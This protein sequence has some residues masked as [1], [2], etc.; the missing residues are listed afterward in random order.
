MLYWPRQGVPPL[1]P[2]P[3]SLSLWSLS[4]PPPSIRPHSPLPPSLPPLR[5]FL[6]QATRELLLEAFPAA[7]EGDLTALEA[8]LCSGA[9]AY[10]HGL[11]FGLPRL[12]ALDAHSLRGWGSYRPRVVGDAFEAVLGAAL[13]ALGWEAARGAVRGAVAGA[14]ERGGTVAA[15]STSSGGAVGAHPH[16]HLA[17]AVATAPRDGAAEVVAAR[18]RMGD[19]EAPWDHAKALEAACSRR[20]LPRPRFR[21]VERTAQSGKRPPTTSAEVEVRTSPASPAADGTSG[22][23][24]HVPQPGPPVVVGVG[25]GLTPHLARQAAALDALE[26]LREAEG[27]GTED[28]A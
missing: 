23:R 21:D 22:D 2:L 1:P 16:P 14:L 20:G 28:A 26:A 25:R 4:I 3:V 17:A 19:R 7:S 6:P 11:S 18:V 13:L 10:E 9:A 27:G 12:V 5:P 8:R 15:A 24:R